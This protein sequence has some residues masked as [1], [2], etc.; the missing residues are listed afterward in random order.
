MGRVILF[1]IL[2]SFCLMTSSVGFTFVCNIIGSFFS[3]LFEKN[4]KLGMVT[5]T[6]NSSTLEVDQKDHQY[7][8][9]LGCKSQILYQN[10]N[11]SLPAPQNI[12]ESNKGQDNLVTSP[13]FWLISLPSSFPILFVVLGIEPGPH[14]SEQIILSLSYIPRPLNIF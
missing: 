3:F 13:H 6:C 1:Y 2:Y 9:S 10:T 7:E 12:R 14:T 11:T 5:H 8:F 4:D